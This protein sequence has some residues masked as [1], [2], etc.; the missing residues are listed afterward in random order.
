MAKAADLPT[1]RCSGIGHLETGKMGAGK[2]EIRRRR[3][4]DAPV[5]REHAGA[6]AQV[7]GGVGNVLDD[8]VRQDEVE[9]AVGERQGHPVGEGKLQ[10]V[11]APLAR[12]AHARLP[13]AIDRID[14]DDLTRL[15]RQRQ[16]HPAAAAAGVENASGDPTRRAPETRSLSRSGNTRTGRS[17]IRNETGGRRAPGWRGRQSCARPVPLSTGLRRSPNLSIKAARSWPD[18]VSATSKLITI[19]RCG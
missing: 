1:S 7:E 5:G 14:A 6:F 12:Q 11:D 18:G 13:E 2:R 3:E 4:I 16:R 15:F 8:G 10:V 17:R 19:R 9:R